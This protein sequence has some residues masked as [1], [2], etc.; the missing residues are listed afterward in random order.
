MMMAIKPKVISTYLMLSYF[1]LCSLGL[2]EEEFE[3]F[4]G[5][6]PTR[7]C[8]NSARLKTWCNSIGGKTGTITPGEPFLEGYPYC[9]DA[10]INVAKGSGGVNKPLKVVICA[11]KYHYY[12]ALGKGRA[13]GHVMNYQ[14][15]KE[16]KTCL[17]FKDVPYS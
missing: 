1:F 10:N 2:T 8:C 3:A 6:D 15:Q 7:Y 9:A 14:C 12:Y 4:K 17:P 11:W 5:E 13:D 16:T